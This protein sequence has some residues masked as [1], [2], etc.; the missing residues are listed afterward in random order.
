MNRTEIGIYA[1]KVWQLLV[2]NARWSYGDLK[3]KSGLR[4][5]DLGAALGWLAHENKVQFDQEEDE[6]YVYLC[7]NVYIG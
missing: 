3:R 5:K 6:L 1:T 7:V 4:D 2:N